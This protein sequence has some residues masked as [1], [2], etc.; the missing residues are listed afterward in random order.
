MKKMM[1]RLKKMSRKKK[2]VISAVI[3]LA[4]SVGAY[5][6]FGFG[7]D[8]KVASAT[9]T[10]SIVRR[11]DLAVT[12]S[13]SG[14]VEPV[15]R[16]DIVA[17][18]K[19]EIIESNFNE[20]DTVRQGDVLYRIDSTD[21]SNSIQKQHNNVEKAQLN[22]N[23]IKENIANLKVK[24]P[25][26]G[27]LTDF[28]VKVDESVRA[29]RIATIIDKTNMVA[30]IPF[31][32]GQISKINEGDPVTVTSA[33]YMTTMK[34]KVTYKSNTPS[35]SQDGSSLYKVEISVQN[36]GSLAPGTSV[37]AT[38]HTSQGDV[39]SPVSGTVENGD[40][41]PVIPKVSGKVIK[42]YVKNNQYV[43]KGDLLFEI[44]GTDYTESYRKAIL[45]LQDAK[46][47]LESSSKELEKYNITSPID[48]IVLSKKAKAGDTI[49]NSA[50]DRDSNLMT[51]A[52]TSKMVFN[53]DVDELEISK[54]KVGLLADITADALPNEK[55]V[56]QVTK[57]ANEGTS[58]NGVTTYEVELTISDP[59][60]LISGMNVNA[61]I[62]V[63]ESKDTLV[64]PVSAVTGIRNGY[65]YVIVRSDY[66]EE[67]LSGPEQRRP[68]GDS[69][70]GESGQRGNSPSN[71]QGG[72]NSQR[73]PGGDSQRGESG[74]RVNRPSFAQSGE[75]G[76]RANRP[77][78][79]QGSENNQRRTGGD[80]QGGGN[81]PAP[82]ATPQTN[83]GA[84]AQ[85]VTPQ[86]SG[87]TQS[88]G[89]TNMVN[90]DLP[91]GYKRI[92]V[93]I[94]LSNTDNIEIKRG[95]KEGDEIFI[96]STPS[97]GSRNNNQ[98]FR[99]QGMGGAP[100]IRTQGGGGNFGGQNN[101]R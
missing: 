21:A 55:F 101:R 26:S 62:I 83:E 14:T 47:S 5:A 20:G 69:Q 72:E 2:I 87:N 100:V 94:G 29:D 84:P 16:F 45:E 53:L 4:L 30:T 88:R 1:L 66:V 39:K 71:A 41:T 6:F 73:R 58:Q 57:V 92:R 54:V 52:D 56:G 75:S 32:A 67:D 76:Q 31:N 23:T 44:D 61:E 17:L 37:G 18:V 11:D 82:T 48:G 40:S 80:S 43:N 99:M 9:F 24:A 25:A 97:S 86:N 3:V 51:I 74:Q 79:A 33:L 63:E 98:N 70:R 89:G 27:V 7:K 90:S 15:A 78:N 77:S 28:N 81:T 95:L 91:E 68:G 65:G 64:V 38:V 42:V 93:Q 12:I 36:P 34:G 59:G 49:G 35:G 46:L 96:P 8:S 85:S 60:N 22:V 10:P 13:G 50:G 19:G